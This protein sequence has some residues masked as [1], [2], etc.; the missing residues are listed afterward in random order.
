MGTAGPTSSTAI[1]AHREG[2]ITLAAVVDPVPVEPGILPGTTSYHSEL[3]SLLEAEVPDVVIIS[4]PIHTHAGLALAAV[5]AGADVLLEKPPTATLAEFEE[6]CAESERAGALVQVGFQSLGSDAL[7]YVKDRVR[8]G[9]IGQVT[10]YGASAGWVRPESYWRRAAWAGRRRVGDRVVA[11]G[12]LTNPLAHATATALALADRMRSDDIVGLT[13]DLHRANDIEADDTSVARLQLRDAPS[14]TTAVSLC[15]TSREEPWVEVVGTEGRI[16][17]YYG[18]DVVQEHTSAGDPPLTTRHDRTPLLW[19]LL[20]ARRD[21]R[22]LCSPLVDSGGFMRL[23]Q[24]VMDA[25]DPMP[26][27]PSH[28]RWV[29][30]AAGRHPIVEGVERALHDAVRTERTFCEA[31]V[32]WAQV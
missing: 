17:F 16:V 13:L 20:A 18:I 5:R 24:G 15:A 8:R 21:A 1:E 31:G 28:V 3:E 14:L 9:A 27:S 2:R 32:A 7:A 4:T 30:D 22:P 23:L 26:I 12:V 29:S 25:A 11:D 6:L 10:R 19:D